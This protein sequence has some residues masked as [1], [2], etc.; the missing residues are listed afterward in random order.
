MKAIVQELRG[1]EQRRMSVLESLGCCPTLFIRFV[2]PV[3]LGRIGIALGRIG[4]V[5]SSPRERRPMR[6][7]ASAIAYR[8]TRVVAAATA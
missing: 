6:L 1:V 4:I 7:A 3:V 8:P 5:L 2:L